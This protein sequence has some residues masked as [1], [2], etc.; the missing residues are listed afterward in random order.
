MTFK[1]GDLVQVEGRKDLYLIKSINEDVCRMSDGSVIHAS[2]LE[3]EER[4]TDDE[5]QDRELFFRWFMGLLHKCDTCALRDV[6]RNNKENLWKE[7]RRVKPY[8]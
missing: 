5:K 6:V 3:L 1:V 4:G 7:W 2:R 8:V